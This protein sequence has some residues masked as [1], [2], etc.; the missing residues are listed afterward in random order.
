MFGLQYA[1]H[2]AHD[3]S[4]SAPMPDVSAVARSGAVDEA[5]S[6]ATIGLDSQITR[7]R[8]LLPWIH[9]VAR[10]VTDY[11][12]SQEQVPNGIHFISRTSWGPIECDRT[13]T[14]YG[15]FDGPLAGQLSRV[16]EAMER[17]GMKPNGTP[18]SRLY[19]LDHGRSPTVDA[20]YGSYDAPEAD[21]QVPGVGVIV[22]PVSDPQGFTLDGRAAPAPPGPAPNAS[23]AGG[24][25]FRALTQVSAV[26][27]T[28]GAPSQAYLVSLT[29][30][31]APYYTDAGP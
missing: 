7:L 26:E 20:A 3:L 19:T 25:V 4:T 2:S 13:V 30:Q 14:W 31:E 27:L 15:S 21:V 18:I 29:V 5:D 22:T 8:Q 24:L 23:P 17:A 16:D 9:P 10:K 6:N 1:L 11:C 28:A 12:D